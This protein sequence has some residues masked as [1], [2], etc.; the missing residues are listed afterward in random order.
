MVSIPKVVGVIS[1]G[2]M[3]CLGLTGNA[4]SAADKMG[5][6]GQAGVQSEEG[7]LEGAIVERGKTIQGEV[8][9]VEGPNYFVKQQDGKE[10]RLHTDSTTRMMTGLVGKG[11]RIEAQV[12]EQNHALSIDYLIVAPHP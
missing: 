7:K 11:D 8:L 1:C 9:R 6:E 5:T 10:V 12:N 4:A 3:L 2:F